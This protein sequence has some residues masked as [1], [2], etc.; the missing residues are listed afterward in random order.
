MASGSG[1]NTIKLWNIPTGQLIRTLTGHTSYIWYSVDLLNSQTLVSGSLDQTIKL[2]NWS[3]GECFRTIQTTGPRIVSL[4]VININQLQQT[5]TTQTS[6]STTPTTKSKLF[7]FN[8]YGR[9]LTSIFKKEL[10][11]ICFYILNHDVYLQLIFR[12][13]I[14]TMSFTKFWFRF[15][16]L[17]R[18]RQGVL[19]IFLFKGLKW[20]SLCIITPYHDLPRHA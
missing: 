15:S 14:F 13:L 9:I 2:W 3:T 6:T 18:K 20:I 11:K 16:N 5:T 8:L 19:I 1:D 17:Y 7:I 12:F 4:S 10:T